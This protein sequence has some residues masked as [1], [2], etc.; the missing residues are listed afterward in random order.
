[1]SIKIIKKETTWCFKMS[2]DFK[3]LVDKQK[4]PK[5]TVKEM[6]EILLKQDMEWDIAY[7]KDLVAFKNS[8]ERATTIYPKRYWESR[9][10]DSFKRLDIIKIG[11]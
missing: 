11:D 1:M 5:K 6:I 4:Q 7:Y 8:C 10:R 2:D 9:M 3:E